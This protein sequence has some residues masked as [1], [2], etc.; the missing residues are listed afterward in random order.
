VARVVVAAAVVPLVARVE[1]PPAVVRAEV[2]PWVARVVA[3]V[4]P[5]SAVRPAAR[6]GPAT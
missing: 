2:P 1:V 4:V 3:V 6:R 5:A